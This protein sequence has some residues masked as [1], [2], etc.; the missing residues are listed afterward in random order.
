[1]SFRF[2]GSP[3]PARFG[4]LRWINLTDDIRVR[5][6]PEQ[7]LQAAKALW[8]ASRFRREHAAILRQS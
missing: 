3:F 2:V 1:M 5:A 8:P 6:R 7:M 4:I